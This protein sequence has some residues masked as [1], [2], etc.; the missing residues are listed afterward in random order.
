MESY[1]IMRKLDP[2]GRIVLPMKMRRKLKIDEGDSV[3]FII[4]GDKIILRKY[5][6]SC[7]FCGKSSDVIEH[8]GKYVCTKCLEELGL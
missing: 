7:I 2:L 5:R 8:R 1:R 6:T 3:E 4:S